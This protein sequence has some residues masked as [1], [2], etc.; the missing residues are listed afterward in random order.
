MTLLVLTPISEV[1]VD[2]LPKRRISFAAESGLVAKWTSFRVF[3]A[4]QLDR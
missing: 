2:Q 1:P 3:G 4:V